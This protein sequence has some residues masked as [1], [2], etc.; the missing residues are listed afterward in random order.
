M[1]LLA[2]LHAAIKSSLL[3]PDISTKCIKAVLMS[4]SALLAGIGTNP[5]L[6]VLLPVPLSKHAL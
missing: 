1:H 3:L 4:C 5:N 2:L 6:Y